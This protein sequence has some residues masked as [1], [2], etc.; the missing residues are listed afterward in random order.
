M[1]KRKFKIAAL[2]NSSLCVGFS[3]T[4]DVIKAEFEY[5]GKDISL[6]TREIQE[7]YSNYGYL[8]PDEIS[9]DIGFKR[10]LYVP[11]NIWYVREIDSIKRKALIVNQYTSAKPGNEK[12]TSPLLEG[13][14]VLKNIPTKW[15]RWNPYNQ[16]FL[17]I[18]QETLESIPDYMKPDLTY[19]PTKHV[20][21][22]L[23]PSNQTHAIFAFNVINPELFRF[24]LFD[25]I[26]AEIKSITSRKAEGKYTESYKRSIKQKIKQCGL[27]AISDN[28]FGQEGV[29]GDKLTEPDLWALTPFIDGFDFRVI[30]AG[31][32]FFTHMGW[33]EL[34]KDNALIIKPE[35]LL[36]NEGPLLSEVKKT[37]D[38]CI[39]PLSGS[40]DLRA[41]PNG[42][43]Y[44]LETSHCFSAER[45]PE[46]FIKRVRENI[47]DTLIEKF[48]LL[49]GNYNDGWE[50]RVSKYLET[51][52]TLEEVKKFDVDLKIKD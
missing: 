18:Y 23:R 1:V 29:Y 22:V 48:D 34:K 16:S 39:T 25:I 33:H 28:T 52:E 41:H 4:L 3:R 44:F 14:K 9:L 26:I 50:E 6:L 47:L 43:F 19:T 15:F 11:E 12:I 2:E 38:N 30:K 17:D 32:E 24:T 46:S 37:M 45:Y 27:E 20:Q 31:N 13:N 40:M 42:K 10:P 7:N 21:M 51:V 5:R 36:D 8:N 35:L 49:I